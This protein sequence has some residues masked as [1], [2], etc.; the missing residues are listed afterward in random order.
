[1]ASEKMTS[2][3]HQKIYIPLKMFFYNIHWK[4]NKTYPHVINFI[5]L[6]PVSYNGKE[7][8]AVYFCAPMHDCSIQVSLILQQLGIYTKQI[9]NN[10]YKSCMNEKALQL[11]PI[12][13]IANIHT[14]SYFWQIQLQ[15]LWKT[16]NYL[17]YISIHVKNCS[18]QQCID[19]KCFME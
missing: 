11:F 7:M 10:N 5:P 1:M 12:K 8:P 6:H 17:I 13:I 15:E 2:R 14:G 16:A 19:R 3:P 18:H 9:V 4:Y